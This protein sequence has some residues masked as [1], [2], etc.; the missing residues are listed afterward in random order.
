M[1][2]I[3]MN[4]LIARYGALLVSLAGSAEVAVVYIVEVCV[5]HTETFALSNFLILLGIAGAVSVYHIIAKETHDASLRARLG[6]LDEAWAACYS[7]GPR[8]VDMPPRASK[9]QTMK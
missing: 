6:A 1:E 5:L 2:D 9:S 7:L 4:L 8:K 3:F